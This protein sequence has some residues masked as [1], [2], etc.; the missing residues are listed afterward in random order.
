MLIDERFSQL[1]GMTYE[2]I[3]EKYKVNNDIASSLKCAAN[4]DYYHV[5]T[6]KGLTNKEKAEKL[7]LT[8]YTV[9]SYVHAL[10]KAGIITRKRP[11]RTEIHDSIRSCLFGNPANLSE[12]KSNVPGATLSDVYND[13]EIEHAGTGGNTVYY[14]REQKESFEQLVEFKNCLIE[15]EVL[16]KI[17]RPVPISWLS[18]ELDINEEKI[19]SNLKPMLDEQ[20]LFR[21]VK[22]NVG[23]NGS[24]TPGIGETY[25]YRP[26]QE[27]DMA[28]I[29]EA[30]LPFGR[31]SSCHDKAAMTVSLR[32]NLPPPLFDE[33]RSLYLTYVPRS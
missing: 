7:E 22:F 4:P 26:G 2:E 8:P 19:S 29:I 16:V 25:F 12:I 10:I 27:R 6:D 9:G 24:K 3:A 1:R 13:S 18:A 33:V 30:N 20:K 21:V 17:N 15:D 11:R 14:L 28:K 5:L 32:R 23:K 31:N